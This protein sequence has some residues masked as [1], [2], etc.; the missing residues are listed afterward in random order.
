MPGLRHA[1]AR[2]QPAT[3]FS[4]A[5]IA[6]FAED[7]LVDLKD[8]IEQLAS[9]QD[10]P[11]TPHWIDTAKFVLADRDQVESRHWCSS[12]RPAVVVVVLA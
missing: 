9:R 5:D 6:H 1:P 11:V 4:F 12:V 10:L 8:R 7:D 3:H 2:G